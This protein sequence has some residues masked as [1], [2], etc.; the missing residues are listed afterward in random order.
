MN[1]KRREYFR[2][3]GSAAVFFCALTVL[4]GAL[5]WLVYGIID[6]LSCHRYTGR[7]TAISEFAP[8][9]IT[10]E[11]RVINTAEAAY[12]YRLSNGE[13]RRGTFSVYDWDND[14]TADEYAV[15][16]EYIVYTHNG[17]SG[18]RSEVW[19]RGNMTDNVSG[20]LFIIIPALIAAAVGGAKTKGLSLIWYVYPKSVVFSCIM[21]L[22]AAWEAVYNLF[23]FEAGGFLSGLAEAFAQLEAVAVCFLVVIAEIIV[24]LAA[25]HREKKRISSLDTVRAAASP[26]TEGGGA[27]E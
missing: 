7:V 16:D 22:L 17:Y 14:G 25:I 23:I 13:V 10:Y 5:P 9:N 18:S 3:A 21:S 1:E 4:M 11:G 12:E 19:A 24:W 6:N 26:E 2:C 8:S 15:G 20:P 27:Y